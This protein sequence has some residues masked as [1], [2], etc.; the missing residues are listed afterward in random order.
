MELPRP[1][2]T[3]PVSDRPS[4]VGA[5]ARPVQWAVAFV[6]GIAAAFVGGRVFRAADARPTDRDR[7]VVVTSVD[8]NQASKTELLQLPGVGE[9]LAD[10]ILAGRDRLGG[11]RTVDDLRQVKGIGPAR[12][13]TLRPYLRID[14]TTVPISVSMYTANKPPAVSL[15]STSGTAGGKKST[16]TA[17]IDLNRATAEELQQLPGV[18]PVLSQRIVAKR[19]AAPF[20]SVDELRKV[21]GIGAKT[22]EKLRPL[23][24]VGTGDDPSAVPQ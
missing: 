18:G 22:L 12:L 7:V 16:P 8:L 1:R 19:E 3:V 11:F 20:K 14:S 10:A 24:T 23:V 6:L 5:A 17:P 4:G 15:K 2:P 21:G 9:S 13:E